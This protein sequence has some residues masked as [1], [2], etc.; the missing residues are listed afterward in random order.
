MKYIFRVF[1]K[2]ADT[3]FDPFFVNTVAAGKRY[4]VHV[5]REAIDIQADCDLY[6]LGRIDDDKII[7]NTDIK[8]LGSFIDLKDDYLNVDLAS[9]KEVN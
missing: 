6:L 3:W 1:D 4:F 8:N 5:M 7:D 2:V 9:L